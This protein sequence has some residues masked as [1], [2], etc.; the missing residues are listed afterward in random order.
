MHDRLIECLR[1]A[2]RHHV[3]DIHFALDRNDSLKIE[4]RVRGVIRELKK[5]EE[6]GR[7]F[8][9]LLYR[10]NLD[11]SN[12]LYPQT[13]SFEEDVDGTVLSLRFALISSYQMTSG[14]M[15]I[16]NNHSLL[17]VDSLSADP[18]QTQWLKG[19]T[20]NRSGLYLI[21]GPTGSGKT[22]A[23][24]TVLNETEGKKIFTLEDP[25]E[26]YSEHFVQLQINEKQH[27]GYAEGIKQLMRHDPDIILIGEIRD[28]QA[29]QM[30]VRCALTGH[31]V[32][33]SIHSSGCVNGIER[34]LELNVSKNQLSD[35][36][37]G[38]SNQRL[39]DTS[40]H[41]KT[42]IYEIMDRKETS[43]YFKNQKTS[44]QFCPLA[45]KI[46]IAVKNGQIDSRQAEQDIP[47]Q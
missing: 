24:Y 36:L 17:T 7:F 43:Y 14:V 47:Q 6:D 32:L 33:S 3:T 34:M 26:V 42:G 13:G 12:T 19:I 11:V 37:C 23:L 31:L 22:T 16:L 29:A 2:L 44:D 5:K 21:S 41:R 20:G 35:V 1:I 15:R 18:I 39:Y 46:R 27:M 28:S 30:A 45:E 9:Y 8:R 38:I 4:M 40:D 10:A 25:I